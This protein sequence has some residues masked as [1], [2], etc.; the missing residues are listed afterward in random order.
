MAGVGLI[1]YSQ[2]VRTFSS[3]AAVNCILAGS[4]TI[5]SNFHLKNLKSNS[6][7]T[8]NREKTYRLTAQGEKK[9]SIACNCSLK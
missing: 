5:L 7:I 1:L 9:S 8:Q 3:N 2:T 6:L 4:C